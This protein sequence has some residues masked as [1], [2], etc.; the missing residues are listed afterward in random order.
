MLQSQARQTINM[1]SARRIHDIA[2]KKEMNGWSEKLMYW[3][4]MYHMNV[5]VQQKLLNMPYEEINTL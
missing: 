4:H 1:L 3:L 2:S 5:E